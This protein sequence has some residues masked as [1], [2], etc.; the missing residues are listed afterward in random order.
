MS[1]VKGYKTLKAACDFD[2]VVV[3]EKDYEFEGVVRKRLIVKRP[4][5]KVTFVVIQYENGLFSSAVKLP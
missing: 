5:G 3:S 2:A 4:T 1:E